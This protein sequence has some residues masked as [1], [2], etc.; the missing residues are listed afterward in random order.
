MEKN[1]KRNF[2]EWAMHYRQI[3]ILVVTCLVAFGVYSLPQMRKNEFPD[4]TVRQGIVVAVAP[5]N[6]AQE[7]V[8]QVTKPL[9]EYIFTYKE[10]KKEKTFS[11]S[12]DGITYIQVELNDDLTNKDEFWSKFKHGVSQ[13]KAQLPP[14][15]LVVV[16]QDDFGDTSALLI[17]M[18]SEDKTYRE[19][20]D[21]MDLLQGRLRRIPAVGRMTVSGMQNE[22]IS[23]YLDHD[24]LSKYG[25]NEQALALSLM[26]KGFTTSGGRVKDGTMVSPIY[27]SR[28]LNTVRDVQEQIVYADPQGNVVRLKDVARVVREYP[29]P[30]SYITNNGRKCLLLSVEMKKGQN[31]VA[32]GEEVN[33][34]LDEFQP[35]FPADVTLFRITDQPKVVDDSV[36]NFLHELIIAIVAVV[37][38]VMLLLP[39]RVALV[40][41][42]TIPITI[43]ISLGLFY[44]FGIELNTVTLAAL[45]VTLGMIVDNSIVIIDS[46]LE[47][48]GEGMS[49]WHA[50]IYS[51][52]HFLKSIFSAT[53]AISITFFPFL[54]TLTGMLNEFVLSFPWAISI[55]LGTSL[56]VATLLVPFMQFW[57]IKPP[58]PLHEEG[59]SAHPSTEEHQSPVPS[60]RGRRREGLFLDLLQ[61]H[62]NWLFGKCFA[63]PKITVAIGAASIVVGAVMLAGLPQRILPVADR[64]QFAVEIYLPTGTDVDVTAQVAD[65]LEHILRQDPRVVSIASFKGCASPRFQTSYAPQIPGTNYAQFIVN[66]TGIRDTEALLDEYTPKYTDY[67]PGARVRFKQLSYSDAAYPI[68]VRLSGEDLSV[69]KHDAETV[70]EVLKQMPGLILVQTDFNEPLTAVAVNL[71]EDEA[72]RLGVTNLGLE[73]TLAMRYGDGLAIANVWEGDYG[74]PVKLKSEKADRAVPTEVKD[75]LIPVAAGLADVPLRQVADVEPVWKEGQI[76]RRNGIYTATVQADLVRR[77]NAMQMIARLQEELKDFPFSPGVTVTYAGEQEKTDEWMPQIIGGLMIAIVIIFFI[78]LAHFRKI[79]IALLI[80]GSMTLCVFGTAFGVWIQGV[81]FS[82]T[83]ILGVTALMGII[84]RNGIIMIDYA[85]ELRAT[86]HMTAEQAIYHSALRRMRPIFLT[87]AAASMGVIPMILGKSSL[88]MPMGTVICYGT[89]ITMVFILTVLPCLYLLTFRGSTERRAKWDAL[90]QQ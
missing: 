87:S 84:V 60:P 34:V 61:K 68:E 71:K 6:T 29:D 83:A 31:I 16:V 27:V 74:I 67:F 25:L 86:E 7:M 44:A 9:E 46:Y 2:V 78:L 3:V 79:S 49:R 80:F 20:D 14:N 43:F 54:F 47:M 64:N 59:L 89:L 76:V 28:S 77:Q 56:L 69:L 66:T 73:S 36:S 22:Q 11:K 33:K 57:F 32:M 35:E 17:T 62:Y 53:L 8:E 75:E 1:K 51:T 40:A 85:E 12:R 10:V 52:T 13:F 15:V 5:G 65:S 72:T 26:Q 55:V 38:V 82:I 58:Q 48:L 45:I 42:S 19:L 23:V 90:E 18:E 24:R 88:W 37:I 63:H 81:D 50:S 39:L 41:A 4:F 70:L 21:Y 30:D